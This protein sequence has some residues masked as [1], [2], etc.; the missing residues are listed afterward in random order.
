[1]SHHDDGTIK[2]S[3][4][5]FNAYARKRGPSVSLPTAPVGPRFRGDDGFS[6][7]LKQFP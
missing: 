3:Q 2:N 4:Q 7:R 5:L 1:M 6:L